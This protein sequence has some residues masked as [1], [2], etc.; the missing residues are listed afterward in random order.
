MFPMCIRISAY[1]GVCEYGYL[2]VQVCVCVHGC[3]QFCVSVYTCIFAYSLTHETSLVMMESNFIEKVLCL[4]LFIRQI[5]HAVSYQSAC[6]PNSLEQNDTKLLQ[7]HGGQGITGSAMGDNLSKAS[8]KEFSR[9][10]SHP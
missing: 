3:V 5:L 9:K 4:S 7:S 2:H 6:P 10:G 8:H 1:V